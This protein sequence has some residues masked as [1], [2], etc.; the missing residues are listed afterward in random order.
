MESL[1]NLSRKSIQTPESPGRRSG[2]SVETSENTWRL[3]D[4]CVDSQ[5]SH[6]MC[7]STLSTVSLPVQL[8]LAR[9]TAPTALVAS[10]ALPPA[11]SPLCHPAVLLSQPAWTPV[12]AMRALSLM[13]T[14]AYLPLNVAVSF[15][16]SSMALVRSFGVTSP[17]PDAVFVTR[18]SGRRCAGILVAARR[19][20]AEWRRGSRI[21]IPKFLGSAQLL[22]LP[23]T[24]P[25][26]ARGSSSRGR[27]STC[28]LAYVRTAKI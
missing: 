21:V 23:T 12:C 14:P 10:P 11:T 20:N 5:V 2:K 6:T 1:E 19:R 28:W 8:S 15:G 4:I 7:H 17:A 18:S 16:V 27:V 9:Q 22:E 3:Q 24:R 13:P 25:L 26:M